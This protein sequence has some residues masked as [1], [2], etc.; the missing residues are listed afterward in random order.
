MKKISKL[1]IATAM[2][3]TTSL[4]WAEAA[5]QDVDTIVAEVAQLSAEQQD[6]IV[7]KLINQQRINKT[8]QPRQGT[9]LLR[10]PT[11]VGSPNY[12]GVFKNGSTTATISFWREV[13]DDGKLHLFAQVAPTTAASFF[14]CPSGSS[15]SVY[16][17]KIDYGNAL[18]ATSGDDKSYCSYVTAKQIFLI[19]QWSTADNFDESGAFSF[20]DP[21]RSAIIDVPALTTSNPSTTPSTTPSTPSTSAV[22]FTQDDL[23]YVFPNLDIEIP[24]A[25]YFQNSGGFPPTT[26]QMPIYVNLKYAP[27][28]PGDYTWVLQSAGPLR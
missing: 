1:V 13:A 2:S 8:R 4:L 6:Q 15:Y 19:D 18:R 9:K 11:A 24:I 12:S 22:T 21:A 10:L 14:F 3:F 7:A 16:Q 25:I 20:T 27:Q 26:T 5:S 17:N 28:K 23:P